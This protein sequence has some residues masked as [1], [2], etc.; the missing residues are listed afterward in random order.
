MSQVITD[1]D[2]VICGAGPVGL[3]TALELHRNGVPTDKFVVLERRPTPEHHGE[4]SSVI[5][6]I[7]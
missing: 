4:C 1:R 2:I 3:Y 7:F 5:T 6:I